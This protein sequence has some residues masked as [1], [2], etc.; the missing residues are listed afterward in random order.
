MART[1]RN[2][3][4]LSTDELMAVRSWLDSALMY[5]ELAEI[6]DSEQ[7]TE[8]ALANYDCASEFAAARTGVSL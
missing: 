6:E 8:K 1:Y 7:N 4:T 3:L 5:A 2:E